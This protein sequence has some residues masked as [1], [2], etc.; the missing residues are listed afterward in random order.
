MSS[1]ETSNHERRKEK[2]K[3][4]REDLKHTVSA[5]IGYQCSQVESRAAQTLFHVPFPLSFDLWTFQCN[6][7]LCTDQAFIE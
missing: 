4:V 7:D 3:D 5:L 1:K 6:R 2:E